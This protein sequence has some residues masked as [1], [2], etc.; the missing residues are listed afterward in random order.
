MSKLITVHSLRNGLGRTTI[1]C[2]LGIKLSEHGNKTLIIDNNYR[3]CDVANYL[4][5]TPNY[6]IDDI[7]PFL[8][9]KSL[10]KDTLKDLVV[11]I[12]KNLDVLAGSKLDTM[13]NILN[14]D[15]IKEI[16]EKAK[17]IYDYIIIDTRAALTH[18][19][20]IGLMDI[21]DYPIVITQLNNNEK[22]YYV[23]Q[24]NKIADENRK[25][26][27]QLISKAIVVIN[28]YSDEIDFDL[29]HFKKEYAE[30][31]KLFFSP[32]IIN[33]C[34][35]FKCKLNEKNEVELMKLLKHI[36]NIDEEDKI[37]K[38]NILANKISK[39]KSILGMV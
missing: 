24:K 5:A 1:A 26:L 18:E 21:I 12:N 15:D 39:I 28:R 10:E 6:T 29:S 22:E 7:K 25:V 16:K 34:N 37:D 3:Y 33:F 9:G 35:G 36:A 38:N 23:K 30:V 4:L 11:S 19:E 17:G 31:I 14:E 32:N 13:V 2:L 8:Q 20:N 27:E